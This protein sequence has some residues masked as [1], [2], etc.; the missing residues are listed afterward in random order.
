MKKKLE[1]K[2]KVEKKTWKKKLEKKNWKKLEKKKLEKKIG[3]KK[4]P[5]WNFSCKRVRYV[6]GYDVTHFPW[7]KLENGKMVVA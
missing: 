5:L 6:Y 7:C 1:N 3:K 4:I 2:K